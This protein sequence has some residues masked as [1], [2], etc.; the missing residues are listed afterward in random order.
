MSVPAASLAVA[1]ALVLAAGVA[2]VLVLTDDGA[3]RRT[4]RLYLEP[5]CTWC[6]I[7]VVVHGVAMGATG[8]VS[9]AGIALVLL[10]AAVAVA[11]PLGD[12]PQEPAR[13]CRRRRRHRRPLRRLALESLTQSGQLTGDLLAVAALGL[14]SADRDQLEPVGPGGERA[15]G[16]GRDAGRRP[17]AAARRTSSSRRIRP[18]PATTM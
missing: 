5:L 12:G 14:R 11:L 1:I 8:T 4:A 3:L 18:E 15:H 16:L 13:R 6:L 7:A 17:T 9:V 2:R 10:I